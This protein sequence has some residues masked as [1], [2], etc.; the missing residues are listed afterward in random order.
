MKTKYLF[1]ALMG[2]TALSACTAD[3]Q[4]AAKQEG[5]PILLTSAV[6]AT[7]AGSGIQSTMLAEG[8]QVNVYISA[9]GGGA[10][11]APIVYNIND[12]GEMTPVGN[13]YPYFPTNNNPVSIY[14][15]YP[16]GATRDIHS[17]TVQTNQ[18]R[19]QQYKLSDLMFGQPLD[20]MGDPRNVSPTTDKQTITFKHKLS[21]ITV[22]LIS[23]QNAPQ[24]SNASIQLCGIYT[25]VNFIP[26]TGTVGVTSGDSEYIT[27]TSKTTVSGANTYTQPV[28]AIVP[29]QTI[30]TGYFLKMRLAMGDVVYYSP[31]QTLTLESGKEY[32][33]NVT[34]NMNNLDV[35]YTVNDWLDEQDGNGDPANIW[36]TKT[37][38]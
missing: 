31:V 27:V 3:E 24:V 18:D 5:L 1:I 14:A 13:V 34:I 36:T 12:N 17:F 19:Q 16:I 21:K 11:Y 22:K 23:G 2:L 7:R 28:S 10:D 8:E 4:P 20:A 30:G 32:K 38:F 37:G 35:S 29:P 26:S 9:V 33:F 25:T 6:D 15:L